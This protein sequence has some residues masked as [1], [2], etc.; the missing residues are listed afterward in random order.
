MKFHKSDS[1]LFVI[2]NGPW[3]STYVIF[4]SAYEEIAT[5]VN[6]QESKV[7]RRTGEFNGLVW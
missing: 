2:C 1:E 4:Q 3:Y 6:T 5:T 7:N